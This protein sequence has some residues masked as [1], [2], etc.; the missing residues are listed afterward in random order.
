MAAAAYQRELGLAH[1]PV[2]HLTA[3][4]AAVSKGATVSVA[5][6]RPL[7]AK[8]TVTLAYWDESQA[9][10]IPVATTL[11]AD[12]RAASAAVKHFSWWTDFLSNADNFVGSLFD[13]RVDAPT[14]TG[15][16]PSWVSKDGITFVDDQNAPVRWCV[17]HDPKN[18]AVLVVKMRVN[19]GY[20]MTVKTT[21]TPAWSWSSFLDQDGFAL[22]K[23]LLAESDTITRQAAESALGL[24]DLSQVVPG[25]SEIDFGFTE[26]A[27]RSSKN[28]GLPLV[29]V[30]QPSSGQVL[31]SMITGSVGDVVQNTPLAYA[32]TF[33]GVTHCV[34]ALGK[35][36]NNLASA[37]YD[38]SQ[39]AQDQIAIVLAG[40]L[41]RSSAKWLTKRSEKEIASLATKAV[42]KFFSV[43][44]LATAFFQAA[45][46]FAD[47]HLTGAA[48]QLSV[49]PTFVKSA[50]VATVSEPVT[51]Q[52]LQTAE[53]KAEFGA[54]AGPMTKGE[55]NP[56]FGVLGIV[57][58]GRSAFGALT[59]DGINDGAVLMEGSGGA[60]GTTNWIG[61]YTDGGKLLGNFSGQEITG[62]RMSDVTSMTISAQSLAITWAA[63]DNSHPDAVNWKAVLRV[64]GGKLMTETI[65][66]DDGPGAQPVLDNPDPYF[67]VDSYLFQSPSKNISC[68]LMEAQAL[69]CWIKESTLTRPTSCSDQP[70]PLA[71]QIVND[72]LVA[73]VTCAPLP[74]QLPAEPKVLPYNHSIQVSTQRCVSTEQGI[75]CRFGNHAFKLS[76]DAVTVS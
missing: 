26:S 17:G 66:K 5:L 72:S 40:T 30:N 54:T 51:D 7:G 73:Q 69:T 61:V 53:V 22:T 67:M 12:R 58:D 42:G 43:A 27:V 56:T 16:A 52:S 24:T 15:S 8:D 3:P 74:E 62:A 48:R 70:W 47:L 64:S 34:A 4:A 63:A 49:F 60:G 2:V 29:E 20:G 6:P 38:C 46:A 75:I 19:R 35:G 32:A 57:P 44:A 65:A 28:G 11:S 21:A 23:T 71:V 25:G 18:A 55:R 76:R 36:A 31:F 45:T 50:P 59:G 10:W 68:S 1:G 37:L 9:N 14:C 41:A 39:T 33:L 13:T